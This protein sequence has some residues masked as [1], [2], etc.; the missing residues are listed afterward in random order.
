MNNVIEMTPKPAELIPRFHRTETIR[1]VVGLVGVGGVAGSIV[2]VVDAIPARTSGISGLNI[3]ILTSDVTAGSSGSITLNS[4]QNGIE[5]SML[6]GPSLFIEQAQPV[7]FATG[8]A[9]RSRW[10][11]L[12]SLLEGKLSSIIKAEPA[13]SP[14]LRVERI[15]RIQG[16]MGLQMQELAQVLLISRPNLYKWLD[17]SKEIALQGANRDRLA[18][19]ERVAS[20]WR[21]QTKAPFSAVAREPLS[22]GRS[23]MELLSAENCV[24]EEILEALKEASAKLRTS[25][26]ST[27]QKMVRAGFTRRKARYSSADDE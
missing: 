19:I 17:S 11:R 1:P 15:A 4:F 24:E 16:A 5:Y 13:P 7:R 12:F 20:A 23:V 3:L 27:S 18:L 21:A 9:G 10:S 8:D 26:M 6:G 14:A 2:Q 22:R 25:A